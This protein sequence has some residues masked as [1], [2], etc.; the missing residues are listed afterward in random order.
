[1]KDNNQNRKVLFL[2]A[3]NV[4]NQ[5]GN[6][7]SKV[8]QKNY[9]LVKQFFGEENTLLCMFSAQETTDFSKSIVIFKRAE[10]PLKQLIAALFGCKIYMPF[11]EKKIIRFIKESKVDLLFIDCSVLG[12]LAKF[13]LGCKT[14]VFYQNSE[15]DYA[16]GK[17][18]NEGIRY[19]P[20]YWVSKYNDFCGTKAN[21]VICLNSRDSNRLKTLYGRGADL[22]MPVTFKDCFDEKRTITEYKRE[23]L[24]LGSFFPPNQISIEWFMREVMPKLKDIQLNIVGKDFETLKDKYECYKNVHVIGTVKELDEYYY[25]HAA[26]VL[27][28]RYGAGMKVKTAEAMMYGRTIFASDEALEGYDV[29]G[30]EG[31]VRCNTPDE[32]AVAINTFFENTSVNYQKSVRNLFLQKYEAKGAEK[33]FADFLLHLFDD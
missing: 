20:S 12:R 27:P 14:I 29:E 10:S 30:V 21:R 7:G 8:S 17:V 9:S 1:M 19:L 24:F 31:I 2:T 32:Y 18:K 28:I 26:V 33:I 13:N 11:E 22:L 4:L 5:Y 3:S 15:A 6:G 23:L 16:F 25:R